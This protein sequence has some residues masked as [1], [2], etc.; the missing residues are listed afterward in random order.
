M[1]RAHGGDQRDALT[2]VA[3]GADPGAQ[4]GD[5]ADCFQCG[6]PVV[7]L[8]MVKQVGRLNKYD[9]GGKRESQ[10][11]T[12]PFWSSGPTASLDRPSPGC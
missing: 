10:C 1:Q 9:R 5:R 2:R 7:L 6:I 12:K 3:P 8:P 4:S 11:A